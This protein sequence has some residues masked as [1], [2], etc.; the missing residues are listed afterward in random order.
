MEESDSSF[1][2]TVSSVL[3]R[4][5]KNQE[6]QDI[7]DD[8]ENDSDKNISH[9]VKKIEEDSSNKDMALVENDRLVSIT[10][11]ETVE[12][13]DSITSDRKIE[14][15]DNG[16]YKDNSLTPALNES[17]DNG[18]NE[19]Y[20]ALAQTELKKLSALA[21]IRKVSQFEIDILV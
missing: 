19:T 1:R 5:C 14:S 4:E 15:I 3:N 10:D 9:E 13:L 17:L 7:I 20:E 18:L 11:K 2:E 8:K 12:H 6:R 16:F 21:H